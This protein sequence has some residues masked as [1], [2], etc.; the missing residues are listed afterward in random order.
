MVLRLPD[1]TLLS[2]TL[3]AALVPGIVPIARG[4]TPF[5]FTGDLLRYTFGGTEPVGGYTW[6]YALTAAGTADILAGISELPFSRVP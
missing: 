1:G 6:R 5:P 3:E 4:F 2:L